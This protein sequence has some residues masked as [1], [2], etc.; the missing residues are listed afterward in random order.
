[1]NS[2]NQALFLRPPPPHLGKRLS[3]CSILIFT[4][5]EQVEIIEFFINV[6]EVHTFQLCFDLWGGPNISYGVLIFEKNKFKG[7]QLLH[8][9]LVPRSSFST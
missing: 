5:Y 7:V 1:M 8:E 3:P 4:I 2:V 6:P 9:K